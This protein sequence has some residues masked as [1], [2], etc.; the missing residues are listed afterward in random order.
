M[1]KIAF[2]SDNKIAKFNDYPKLKFEAKGEKARIVVIDESP[3]MEWVHTLRAPSIINGEVVMETVTNKDG[4]TSQKVKQDFVGQHLCLGNENTLAEKFKDPANCPTCAASN[5][6]EA[7]EPPKRR[8][9]IHIVRYKVQPGSFK[10]QTPF[11]A[12]L[13]AWVFTDKVFDSLVGIAEEHGDLR[14]K[15]LLLECSNKFF[16]NV[17][18]QVGGTAAWLES[19]ENKKFVQALYAENKSEDL[20]TLLAR[21]ATREQISEDISKVKLRHAQAFGGT[22]EGAGSAPSQSQAA[23]AVALDEI[24]SGPAETPASET[25]APVAAAPTDDLG[26]DVVAPVADETPVAA[27]V[28]ETEVAAVEPEAKQ[29]G[30]VLD[31]DSLL[32]GL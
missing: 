30:D 27:P 14:K 22:T 18:I 12:E 31:F 25:P 3:V 32:A 2:N 8:F 23:T 13:L 11:Q 24:L 9:G 17:E 1:A 5:E 21:K 16:Q 10:V 29:G 6:S 4:S 19:D 20:T 15:D 28:A 26:L 7:I